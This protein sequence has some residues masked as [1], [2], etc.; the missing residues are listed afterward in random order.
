MTFNKK[1]F[2]QRQKE[3]N[4]HVITIHGKD[5]IKQ[6]TM[7]YIAK[8]IFGYIILAI[9]LIVAATVAYTKYLENT[10]MQLDAKK[11]EI[12]QKYHDLEKQKLA[13]LNTID[14]LAKNIQD[15]EKASLALEEQLNSLGEELENTKNILGISD[16]GFKLDSTIDYTALSVSEK[17]VIMN[18][19]PNGKPMH[20]RRNSSGFGWRVHP[21]YG[22]KIF[23]RGLD[24]SAP[25]GTKVMATA[26][27]IVET[28][29]YND[30]SGYGNLIVIKHNYGFKTAYA[31]LSRMNVK[32]GDYVT[33]GQVI[34]KSGNSG[35][36][37]GP[38]LHY[39][40]RYLD[41]ILNPKVFMTWNDTNFV[42]TIKKENRVQWHSLIKATKATIHTVQQALLLQEQKSKVK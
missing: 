23:H 14:A 32:V 19:V 20:G 6:I 35:Q 18:F 36:S 25:I 39:E 37:T 41:K 12:E 8:K 42:D 11:S 34:A 28:I 7:G 29:R 31:H 40:V 10:V 9:L 2:L 21:I 5:G 1:A 27:G 17:E 30:G 16:E 38:H 13:L 22:R 4:K 3:R 15:K 33:K 24:I 26:N